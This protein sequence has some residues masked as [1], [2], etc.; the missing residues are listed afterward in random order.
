MCPKNMVYPCG[1]PSDSSHLSSLRRTGPS[2]TVGL[3]TLAEDSPGSGSRK[4]CNHLKRKS[5]HHGWRKSRY[6][7][8][9]VG[10]PAVDQRFG[11]EGPAG[12]PQ[13]RPHIR[14]QTSTNKQGPDRLRVLTNR[15]KQRHLFCNEDLYIG[16]REETPTE[17]I[18]PCLTWLAEKPSEPL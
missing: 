18:Y 10:W 8:V 15:D 13:V 2:F 11:P 6:L 12:G 16:S 14:P 4:P 7:C 5:R 17:G 9:I 3:K 1:L